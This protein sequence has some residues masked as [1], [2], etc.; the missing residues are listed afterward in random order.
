MSNKILII[1]DDLNIH[2]VLRLYFAREDYQ[3]VFA[4]NGSLGLD[5]FR[6][7]KPDVVIL[8]I[9]LPIINGWEVCQLIRKDSNVPILMLTS[10]DTSED[11]LMGFDYGADDYVIKPFDPKEIVARVRA[12]LKRVANFSESQSMDTYNQNYN[13][14]VLKAGSITVNYETYEVLV[15]QKPVELTPKEIQLLFF[16]LKH[17]KI[18]FTRNQLLN[19]VWGDE[20]YGETRTV[21]VHV[22]RLREKLGDTNGVQ[23]KTVWG[24]GYKIEVM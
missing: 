3:L 4:E 10:K 5:R 7:E 16:L 1:D 24:V 20:Y 18:V 9:M 22:K 12:L 6:Q 15:N 21:D 17:P 2:E 19:K 14:N 13:P 8:D 23:L 11:K